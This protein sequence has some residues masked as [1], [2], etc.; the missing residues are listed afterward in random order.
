MANREG[1]GGGVF[2]WRDREGAGVV[3]RGAKPALIA[4]ITAPLR[5]NGGILGF[6]TCIYFMVNVH[7]GEHGL[8]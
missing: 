3:R 1:A 4:L 8:G 2:L 5:E 7:L 6:Y